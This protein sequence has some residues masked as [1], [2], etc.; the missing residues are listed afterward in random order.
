[1]FTFIQTMEGV[2]FKGALKI[3]AETC[4][5]HGWILPRGLE[6]QLLYLDNPSVLVS[7][8]RYCS[9]VEIF[10]TLW[11]RATTVQVAKDTEFLRMGLRRACVLNKL[12]PLTESENVWCKNKL[13]WLIKD[14]SGLLQKIEDGHARWWDTVY[15]LR[16]ENVPIDVLTCAIARIGAFSE[17]RKSSHSSLIRHLS[18]NPVL[19][20]PA[21]LDFSGFVNL[22]ESIFSLL[23]TRTETPTFREDVCEL[24][25]SLS[26]ILKGDFSVP[27]VVLKQSEHP[28]TAEFL[29][30]GRKSSASVYNRADLMPIIAFATWPSYFP[31]GVAP[32]FYT[33]S[34][35]YVKEDL[36]LREMLK[37]VERD[38]SLFC[39]LAIWNMNIMRSETKR[40][41]L[42]QMI[43][44]HI[45]MKM[46]IRQD[47]LRK[48]YEQR[49]FVLKKSFPLMLT[50]ENSWAFEAMAPISKLKWRA[51]LR[52]A[53]GLS[54][55]NSEVM[56]TIAR[57]ISIFQ[58]G[59][60]IKAFLDGTSYTLGKIALTLTAY[61]IFDISLLEG[62]G[63]RAL[64]EG[65]ENLLSAIP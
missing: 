28:E 31:V 18:S 46:P 5:T 9:S 65:L 7:L 55:K 39:L 10:N 19:A 35:I 33:Y 8:A 63:L 2:D 16:N 54:K 51:R 17:L 6:E 25:L 60:P 34:A 59:G 36:A 40:A 62:K 47:D 64:L 30:G 27:A 37:A 3:L 44:G 42:Q 48:I 13:S 15:L 29:N 4:I 45:P 50:N 49:I 43:S 14:L 41:M 12:I 52:G 32:H 23:D 26:P 11:E 61:L 20:N 24:L 57:E 1:M 58:K 21:K 22:Q 38:G 56:L 53:F